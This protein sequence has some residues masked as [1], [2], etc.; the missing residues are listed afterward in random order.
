MSAVVRCLKKIKDADS[1]VQRW[2][3]P[4][5]RCRTNRFVCQITQLYVHRQAVS[6]LANNSE[7]LTAFYAVGD[8]CEQVG[9]V[10]N[11]CSF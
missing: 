1:C 11:H 9:R 6:V 10:Y 5:R 2:Q 4:D 7:Q 8:T 3:S